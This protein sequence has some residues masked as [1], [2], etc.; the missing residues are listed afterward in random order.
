M[1]ISLTCLNVLDIKPTMSITLR[2]RKGWRYG[3]D[4]PTENAA[5]AGS[6]HQ[7]AFLTSGGA[8]R[9]AHLVLIH[10]KQQGEAH[11][12]SAGD[13]E[14]QFKAAGLKN[15]INGIKDDGKKMRLDVF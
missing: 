6:P 10:S 1:N 11:C 2:Q 4:T 13:P 8:A 9:E 5:A 14:V 7:T 15:K 12:V 3:C